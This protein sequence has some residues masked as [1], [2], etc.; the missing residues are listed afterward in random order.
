M[1]ILIPLLGFFLK[2]NSQG[3]IPP[4][5][6]F[7]YVN[8]CNYGLLDRYLSKSM[9]MTLLYSLINQPTVYN[10]ELNLLKNLTPGYISAIGAWG[11]SETQMIPNTTTGSIYNN[12]KQCIWDVDNIYINASVRIPI[13]EASLYEA[14]TTDIN[15]VAIPYFVVS[16]FQG[17]PD[18]IAAYGN[19][20]YPTQF[21]INQIKNTASNMQPSQIGYQPNTY[22]PDINRI[23]T[24]MWFYYLATVYIDMGCNSLSMAWFDRTF[25]ND[26]PGYTKT[27]DLFTKIRTYAQNNN[28]FV[29]ITAGVDRPIYYNFTNQLIF[30]FL[31]SPIRPD[32]TTN[33]YASTPCSAQYMAEINFAALNPQFQGYTG[34]ISPDGIAIDNIPVVFVFD[35]SGSFGYN[36]WPTGIQGNGNGPWN[37]DEITWYYLLGEQCQSYFLKNAANAIKNDVIHRGYLEMPGETPLLWWGS[38]NYGYATNYYMTNF[39]GVI[40]TV[41]NEIWKL[42]DQPYYTVTHKCIKDCNNA[43]QEIYDLNVTTPDVLNIYT[44]HILDVTTNNWYPMT[45]GKERVLSNLPP[46]TYNIGLRDD[47]ASFPYNNDV[48]ALNKEIV[49]T[50]SNF[51]S[52]SIPQSLERKQKVM[53]DPATLAVA[54]YQ[55]TTASNLSLN[56]FPNPANKEVNINFTID[57][58]S[59]INISMTDM[60]GNLIKTISDNAPYAKG[61]FTLTE[62]VNNF[63]PGT[64][65]IEMT[66]N[67]KKITAKLTVN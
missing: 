7:P 26:A 33:S 4:P 51:C 14:V 29:L 59:K 60:K 45:Y 6:N 48:I 62:N 66:S 12:E 11:L 63:I 31:Q 40:G 41:Q 57:E 47:N 10:G 65:F 61:S 43:T 34:G 37:V 18:F 1:L 30:D 39:P 42:N 50:N 55:D 36:G 17:D 67:L 49:V 8:S 23:Q 5:T 54:K 27:Y 52:N 46:G 53:T 24:R 32:P 56:V 16:A 35:A 21:N 13:F 2:G 20:S 44:W 9:N 58:P 38:Q 22:V 25:A 19:N 3:H 64:Y 15:N 28:T